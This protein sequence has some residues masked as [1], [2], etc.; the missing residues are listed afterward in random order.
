MGGVCL[1]WVCFC[2]LVRY[3]CCQK[4][5]GALLVGVRGGCIPS[6]HGCIPCHGHVFLAWPWVKS[7]AAWKMAPR[8]SRS[9]RD[10]FYFFS[11]LRPGNALPHHTLAWACGKRRAAESGV[12]YHVTR[13]PHIPSSPPQQ[14]VG[15]QQLLRFRTICLCAMAVCVQNS[16]GTGQQQI[17]ASPLARC[18]PR[19]MRLPRPLL[20]SR[21]RMIAAHRADR[22]GI[23]SIAFATR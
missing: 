10:R 6:D 5:G 2:R 13:Q 4:E 3:R 19:R 18:G 22:P 11:R 20:T 9:V 23:Q 16:M 12:F 1:R 8:A 21:T 7:Q 15:D 17:W 14:H